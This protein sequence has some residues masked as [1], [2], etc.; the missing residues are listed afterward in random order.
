MLKL[1]MGTILL[2]AFVYLALDEAFAGLFM[3]EHAILIVLGGT[4]AMAI[5]STTKG[6]LRKLVGLCRE[7]LG[8]KYQMGDIKEEFS[9][10]CRQRKLTQQSKNELINYASE[11]WHDGV[12]SDVFYQLITLKRHDIIEQDQRTL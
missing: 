9:I 12:D 6:T 5:S 1:S 8:G 11:L 10:L 7:A 2:L 3:N 4:A